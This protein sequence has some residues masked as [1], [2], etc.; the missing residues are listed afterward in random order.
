MFF[1]RYCLNLFTI[2]IIQ[3]RKKIVSRD[4]FVSSYSIPSDER[5]SSP[6][7]GKGKQQQ[8]QKTTHFLLKLCFPDKHYPA[9]ECNFC[10]VSE[11]S[12]LP[13]PVVPCPGHHCLSGPA[14]APKAYTILLVFF[15]S[16]NS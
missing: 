12:K 14:I 1:L 13:L 3:S 10:Y 4:Q 16:S 8:Q 5:C 9:C 7:M 11:A 15:S 2:R 6:Y